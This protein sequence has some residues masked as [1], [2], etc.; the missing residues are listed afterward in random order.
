ML[1]PGFGPRV[2]RQPRED[3]SSHLSNLRRSKWETSWPL[4]AS[5]G[6]A[7]EDVRGVEVETSMTL[8]SPQR[9]GEKPMKR[10]WARPVCEITAEADPGLNQEILSPGSSISHLWTQDM[11]ERHRQVNRYWRHV[12]AVPQS[13]VFLR[14]LEPVLVITASAMALAAWNTIAPSLWALPPLSLSPITHSVSGSLLSL[15]L[16]FRTNNAN[17]RVNEARSLLATMVKCIRDLVRMSQYIPQQTGA[18]REQILCYTRAFPYALLGH[19]RKGRAVD[20]QDGRTTYRVDPLPP[21]TR[22]LGP[23]IAQD[24]IS[25]RSGNI[26]AHILLDMSTILHKS[27]RIGMS[28]QIHQQTELVLKVRPH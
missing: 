23:E 15:M 16:V 26:P 3:W 20:S 8:P 10:V 2:L 6:S 4:P 25:Q 17:A 28:T 12:T 9:A 21:L 22:I 18:C 13:T 7:N 1:R 14:V 11:W 27:L 24:L 5:S 19:I